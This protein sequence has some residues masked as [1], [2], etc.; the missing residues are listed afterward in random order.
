MRRAVACAAQEMDFAIAA[1][2]T[3]VMGLE[4]FC[5]SALRIGCAAIESAALLLD[6]CEDEDWLCSERASLV[7]GGSRE[8]SVCLGGRS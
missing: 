2:V 4:R 7:C 5:P 8:K 1:K 3:D 6:W